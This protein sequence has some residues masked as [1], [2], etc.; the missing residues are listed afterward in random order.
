[1]GGMAHFTHIPA[2]IR[3]KVFQEF[4]S[5]QGTVSPDTRDKAMCHIIVLAL[6][7]NKFKLTSAS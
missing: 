6:L 5:V 1:M 3:H 2:A 7:V 4:T